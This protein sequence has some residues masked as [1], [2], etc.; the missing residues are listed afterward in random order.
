MQW[1]SMLP[2]LLGDKDVHI[3]RGP[4]LHSALSNKIVDIYTAILFSL[5]QLVCSYSGDIELILTVRSHSRISVLETITDAEKALSLFNGHRTSV[6]LQ[7]LL[8]DAR[9]YNMKPERETGL[10]SEQTK[11]LLNDLHV[12]DPRLGLPNLRNDGSQAIHKVYPLLHHMEQYRQFLDWEN[13]YDKIFWI[14]SD[15]GQ[16]K[17]LLLTSI[18]RLLS[19]HQQQ[20]EQPS[21]SFFFFDYSRPECDNVAAA[22][23]NLIWLLLVNQPSLSL[24]LEEKRNSIGRKYFDDPN[25]FLVLS[26]VFYDM[27]N[28]KSFSNTYFVVDALDESFCDE[29]QFGVA[30]FLSLITFSMESS[31]KVRWLVSSNNSS[32]MKKAFE[33]RETEHL[34][35]H[36]DASGV[37]ATIDN[38]IHDKVAQ[39]AC[40]KSYDDELRTIVVETISKLCCG[41]YI[42]V[43]IV[44][45]ALRAEDVWH[46]EEF[47]GGLESIKNLTGLYAHMRIQ[48]QKIP[49]D[50]KFCNKVLQIMAVAERPLHIDELN[51]LV[52]LGPR[53]NLRIIL[54]KCS[55]F[56]RVHDSIVS[57][58]Y[59][60]AR[61]Y[62]RTHVI[63]H[64]DILNTHVLLARR[65]LEYLIISLGEKNGRKEQDNGSMLAP[66]GHRNTPA[67]G[68]Y[69]TLHWITHLFELSKYLGHRNLRDKFLWSMI[70]SKVQRF[71]EGHFL[72]WVEV[73]I[74][75]EQLTIAAANL[76]KVD[77]CLQ[78]R[79]RSPKYS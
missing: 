34:D 73:L 53:V 51:H 16:G 26:S 55:P 15:A 27:I 68:N 71:V 2:S 1:Y 38:Y 20:E 67:T 29:E 66:V 65:C 72:Q 56:I 43:D 39:I 28:D 64:I 59:Q 35:L 78:K 58:Q 69:A 37:G 10:L 47:L 50:A 22:L 60:S 40:D 76:Q 42:W 62:V 75:E 70:W 11:G 6:P 45:T 31:K 61:G 9:E 19:E 17:T 8:M 32:R 21:L 24:H 54:Q 46:V 18:V 48:I 44:C 57:F 49:K 52:Q 12:T 3:E 13:P 77:L 23:K 79:V 14:T 74:R 25:D 7:K 5:M 41:D 33:G 4:S 30:D 63:L 36:T